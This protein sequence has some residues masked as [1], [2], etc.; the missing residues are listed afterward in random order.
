MSIFS[1]LW[2]WVVSNWKPL[3]AL[4]G[5]LFVVYQY[6][7]IRNDI[8]ENRSLEIIKSFYSEDMIRKSSYLGLVMQEA[9]Q[10]ALDIKSEP[11]KGLK[12]AYYEEI[13]KILHKD[14]TAFEY[15]NYYI[16]SLE[17]MV[18]CINQK[19]CER[20]IIDELLYSKGKNFLIGYYPYICENRTE[21]NNAAWEPLNEHFFEGKKI[22]CND[23]KRNTTPN[24]NTAP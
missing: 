20:S 9:A 17:R 2:Q 15:F 23:Y 21:R 4:V 5:F 8:K 22:D 14:G 13:Q 6:Y 11:S 19:L 24:L 1:C 18:A 16:Y 12:Q 3:S 10:A 7:T